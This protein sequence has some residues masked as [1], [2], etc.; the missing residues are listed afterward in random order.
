MS[1]YV[2]K[3]SRESQEGE[4]ENGVRSYLAV[5]KSSEGKL[6]FDCSLPLGGRAIELIILNK[7]RYLSYED[8]GMLRDPKPADLLTNFR[9]H[10]KLG[11]VLFTCV[12][13]AFDQYSKDLDDYNMYLKKKKLMEKYKK[14]V[15]EVPS[16]PVLARLFNEQ[17]LDLDS[18][19]VLL[20][21]SRYCL[22]AKFSDFG[23]YFRIYSLRDAN[24]GEVFSEPCEV[25]GSRADIPAW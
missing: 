18:L 12:D 3:E 17:D 20:N 15:A 24:F 7:A 25:L 9:K 11:A 4:L 5:F 16:V 14:N 21:H 1:I 23:L 8:N 2:I 6:G 19:D 22:Q 13:S 10:L